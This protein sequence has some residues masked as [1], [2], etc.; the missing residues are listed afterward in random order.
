MLKTLIIFVLNYLK[1][2]FLRCF[3]L[4][5]FYINIHTIKYIYNV[6]TFELNITQ[7]KLPLKKYV[8]IFILIISLI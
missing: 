5:E 3:F 8:S 6:Y 2:V 1:H 4:C 7:K